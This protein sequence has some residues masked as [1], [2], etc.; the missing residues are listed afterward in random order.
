MA[1]WLDSQHEALDFATKGIP[2]DEFDPIFGSDL[3]DI[4][5]RKQYVY[6]HPSERPRVMIDLQGA[7]CLL[8]YEGYWHDG[9]PFDRKV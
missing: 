7:R 2:V 1:R 9:R 8:D 6:I 3:R 5:V 4:L